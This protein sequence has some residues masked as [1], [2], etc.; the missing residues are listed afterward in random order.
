MP[1]V[2]ELSDGDITRLDVDA[3]VNAANAALERGGGVCGAIHRVA[4]PGLADECRA[5]PEVEPGVRCPAGE[6]RITGGHRL[7]AKHVIHTVGPVW[8]GGDEGEAELLASCYRR[9]L[10]LAAEHGLESVAFPAISCG[11]YGYRPEDA[12]PVALEA[13]REFLRGE[14]PVRRVVLACFDR[15]VYDLYERLLGGP[16]EKVG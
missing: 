15:G 9:S 8:R 10:E 13:V 4:G 5:V 6:A 11:V 16:R 1:G 7:Q 2:I 12:C 3:V 14:T